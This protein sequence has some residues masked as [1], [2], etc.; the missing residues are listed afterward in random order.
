MDPCSQLTSWDHASMFY[1]DW[2]IW[3]IPVPYSLAHLMY[4]YSQPTGWYGASQ[5]HTVWSICCILISGWLAHMIHSHSTVLHWP[6]WKYVSPKHLWQSEQ[7]TRLNITLQGISC[8]II[9]ENNQEC[10][11]QT[12]INPGI[13]KHDGCQPENMSDTVQNNYSS[14]HK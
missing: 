6:A 13:L 5:F 12:D 10:V 4:L 14:V 3:C 8:H 11:N 9:I 7:W 1:T 2:P